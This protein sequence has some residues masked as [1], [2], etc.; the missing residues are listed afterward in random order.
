[1]PQQ[2]RERRRRRRRQQVEPR[3]WK[4]GAQR[5]QRRL[6]QQQIAQVGE[7]DDE[8]ALRV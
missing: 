7:L 6:A 1:V 2:R 5:A 3:V 4:G 8:D